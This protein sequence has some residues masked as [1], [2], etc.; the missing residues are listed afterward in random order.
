[1]IFSSYSALYLL[2]IDKMAQLKIT[3]GNRCFYFEL[4]KDGW[5]ELLGKSDSKDSSFQ[6]YPI[7]EEFFEHTAITMLKAWGLVKKSSY[8]KLKIKRL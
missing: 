4:S 2:K 1:V 7:G 5:V 6:E 3:D 8:S